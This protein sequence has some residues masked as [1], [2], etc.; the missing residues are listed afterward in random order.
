MLYLLSIIFPEKALQALQIIIE[1][2]IDLET[3]FTIFTATGQPVISPLA[4]PKGK[5]MGT[6]RDM[7]YG[8][9]VESADL[10]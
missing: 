7:P 5:Q 1:S 2:H 10:T 6:R 9:K 4:K 3:T 8:A